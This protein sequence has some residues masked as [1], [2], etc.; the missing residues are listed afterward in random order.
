[1]KDLICITAHCPTEEK[2]KILYNLVSSLQTI[3]EDFDL[4]V[5]SHTPVTFDVQENVDW[6]IFDKDNEILKDWKYQ[7][8]PWFSPEKGKLIQSIF[9]GIGNTYLTY[10]NN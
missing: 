6:V 7:N 8:H 4:I 2:R 10:I 1:M 3:R 9:F 5:I